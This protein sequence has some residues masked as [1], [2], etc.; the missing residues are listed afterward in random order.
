M[1]VVV[2]FGDSNT[3]GYDPDTR[4]RFPPDMRWTGVLARALGSEFTVIEEGLNGRTTNIDDPLDEDR[5]GKRHLPSRLET[6]APFNLL[7]IMLGTNDL[8]ARLNRSATDIAQSAALLGQTAARSISGVGGAA[9]AVLLVAPPPVLIVDGMDEFLAGADEKSAAFARRYAWA[10][11]R[12]GLHFMDAG[13]VITSSPVDGIHF[14]AQNHQR[15]GV[16]MAERVSDIL[17]GVV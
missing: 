16:A 6:H 10:A 13:S 2:C 4:S 14:D 7:I 9:P 17:R 3:W 11:E 8:R 12:Y 15:L 1:P 5:N